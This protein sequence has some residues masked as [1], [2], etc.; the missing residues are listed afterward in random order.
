[1]I[2]KMIS[3]NSV[4]F[5]HLNLFIFL[6]N[7]SSSCWNTNLLREFF[8]PFPIRNAC[9]FEALLRTKHTYSPVQ[10]RVKKSLRSRTNSSS[11]VYPAFFPAEHLCSD[12][13]AVSVQKKKKKQFPDTFWPQQK[14]ERKPKTNGNKMASPGSARWVW[15]D[16]VS[17]YGKK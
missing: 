13:S 3:I 6:F 14:G 2:F 15:C 1:M 10:N 8:S 5:S 4:K 16:K 11:A 7:P 12:V 17:I 9:W